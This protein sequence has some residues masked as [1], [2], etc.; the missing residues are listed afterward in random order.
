MA[1][2]IIDNTDIAEFGARLLSYTV[3]GTEL[4]NTIG[5]TQNIGIPRLYR[6]D[7]G[8]RKLT[9]TV[10]FRPTYSSGEKLS[11]K[12]KLKR[13]TQQKNRLDYL[14]S[15]STN[16]L[17]PDG[18]LYTS[19]LEVIGDEIMDGESLEVTYQLTGIRRSELENLPGSAVMCHSTAPRT[20]CCIFV[21]VGDDWQSGDELK[22]QIKM[23]NSI[24]SFWR[25]TVENVNPGDTIEING[26]MR[27]IYK[28]GENVFSSSAFTTFPYL[29]PGMNYYECYNHPDKSVTFRTEYYP[30]FL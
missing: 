24:M 29:K 30:T 6:T 19:I 25:C 23:K 10:V 9:V 27:Y 26:L 18:F 5:I 14:L 4:T 1:E 12:D 8:R 3:G 15:G 13:L 21:Y 7:Y 17:L 22:L 16:I 20:D 2:M 28:S 11:V